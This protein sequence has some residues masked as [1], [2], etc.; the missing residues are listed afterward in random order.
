MFIGSDAIIVTDERFGV[1][2]ANAP[3]LVTLDGMRTVLRP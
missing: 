2:N 3:I 1:E